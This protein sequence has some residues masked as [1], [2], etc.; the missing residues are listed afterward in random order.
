M[1]LSFCR[2]I[3]YNKLNNQKTGDFMAK[4]MKIITFFST[5][6]TVFFSILY[7]N[8]KNK[9]TLSLMITFATISYHFIMRLFVGFVINLIFNNHINYQSKWFHISTTEEKLYKIFKVKKWKGKM[10]TYN[11]ENFDNKIHSW[12]EIAQAMC[13][14]ELVHELIIILSFVPIFASIPFDALWIFVITSVLSAC[15]DALFV[16]IQRYN[17]PRI[18]KLI[19]NSKKKR[20]FNKN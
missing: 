13:Q 17:R 12:D 3:C 20:N 19:E 15:F 1:L 14:A 10:A 5:V 7:F 2:Y 6:I 9:L 16:I 4:K 11:P 18:I 8:T